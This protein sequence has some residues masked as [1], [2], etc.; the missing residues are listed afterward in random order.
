MSNYIMFLALGSFL[1]LIAYNAGR[2]DAAH[3]IALRSGCDLDATQ[4][5]QLKAAWYGEAR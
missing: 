4:R 5:S 1:L 3:R 2:Y